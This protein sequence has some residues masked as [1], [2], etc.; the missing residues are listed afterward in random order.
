[1]AIRDKILELADWWAAPGKY[2]PTEE[3]LIS[4]FSEG[5]AEA[6]PTEK[7]ATHALT[8]LQYGVQVQ[9]RVKHW[10]GV[11]ACYILRQAG[12][13]ARW[14]LL[15]GKIVGDGVTKLPGHRNIVPGDIAIINSGDHHF[16]VT[17]I[18]YASNTL[19]S[20]DGNAGWQYIRN[21]KSKKI[22]YSGPHASTKSIV[23]FYRINS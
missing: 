12:V 8:K 14:T 6:S 5:G 23:A 13:K 21:V 4:F 16:I 15:T 7:E 22:Q 2:R 11:F 20:V 9:G 19:Q 3:E 17:D 1:M 10:C 18:D